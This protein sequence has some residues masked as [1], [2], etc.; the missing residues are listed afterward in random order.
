MNFISSWIQTTNICNEKC[1]Y[2]FVKQNTDVM[3]DSTY[4]VLE[5]FLLNLKTDK[6]HLRFAGGEPLLVFNFWE[7]FAIRML[8]RKNVTV[9]VL[10]NLYFVPDNFWNFANLDNVNISISID[11][12]PQR[13]KLNESIINKLSR[14]KNPWIMTTLTDENMLGIE[15][16]AYFIGINKYGWSITTDYFGEINT[17]PIKISEKIISVVEILRKTGYDFT[18]ISFNNCSMNSNFSGCR[19]GKEMIAVDCNGDIYQCQ[20][21][22]G[23]DKKLGDIFSGYSTVETKKKLGCSS[24]IIEDICKGWCPLHYKFSKNSCVPMEIFSYLILKEI[25]NAV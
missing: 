14:I 8:E 5:G 10:T 1:K 23:I 17:N 21:V 22:I 25:K 18:R 2:C 19:A 6:I 3:Q 11:N 20:T 12:N 16:L 13:K 9:E 15:E 24:C 4:R 7:E